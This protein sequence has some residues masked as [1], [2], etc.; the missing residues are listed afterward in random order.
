MTNRPAVVFQGWL[1]GHP[2]AARVAL[3]FD[4][5]RHPCDAGLL[6]WSRVTDAAGREWQVVAH[7]GDE[8]AF[9]LRFRTSP[10]HPPRVVVITRGEGST[11]PID[12][13]TLAD[14]LACNEA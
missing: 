8:L 4:P 6:A 1:G 10:E 7:R 11:G 3:A 9:R 2:E 13:S 12:V 14:V 5:D